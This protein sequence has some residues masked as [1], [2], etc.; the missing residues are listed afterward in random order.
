MTVND[1][2]FA[3][4]ARRIRSRPCRQ[5]ARLVAI[6]GP[7]G[8]GKSTFAAKLAPY[9][10]DAPIIPMDDFIAW[11]DLTDYFPRFEE[12]V[13]APLLEGRD[14]HYQKRDWIDDMMG[15]GLGEFRDV[16]FAEIVIFEGIGSAQRA[17]AQYLSYTIWIAAPEDLRLTRG[18]Q[19]DGHIDGMPA[20]W[21]RF[22][23]REKA[24]FELEHTAERADLV[25]DGTLPFAGEPPRFRVLRQA[26][27]P[28][29][30]D[31]E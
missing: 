29:R 28:G 11:D 20:V 16:P 19:R 22:M 12:Q 1:L 21:E 27:E 14:L 5:R 2:H 31:D 26:P 8:S 4:L 30:N 15:R 13:L 10:D 25:T 17:L 7:G 9:L 18:M 23:A 6:D 3:E 24:F